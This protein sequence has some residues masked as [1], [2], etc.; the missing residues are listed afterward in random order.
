MA[1]L[2]EWDDKYSVHNNKL[3]SEHR[4]L[5]YIFSQLYDSCMQLVSIACFER[6]L[7]QLVSYAEHHFSAEEQYMAEKGYEELDNHREYHNF[8]QK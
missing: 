3:D 6:L 5:F 7:G 4:E 2:F 1:P 8:F